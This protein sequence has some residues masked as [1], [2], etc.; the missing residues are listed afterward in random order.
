MR[1]F[2]VLRPVIAPWLVLLILV[3]VGVPAWAQALDLYSG[4]AMVV[5]Q[6]ESERQ[7]AVAPAFRSALIRASGDTSITDDARLAALLEQAPQWVQSYAFRQEIAAGPDGLASTRDFLQV[8]FDPEAVRQALATLDRS[9]WSERPRTL[10]W[11]VI[12]D[13]STRRI[14]S[15]AEVAALTALTRTALDR[16]I[17]LRLPQLDRE[18][19]VLVDADRLWSEPSP[20]ALAPAPRYGAAI[21]LVVRLARQGSG[22]SA[23]FSLLDGGRVEHW[24]GSYVDANAA[25]TAAANGLA[26]R[27]A[28]RFALS[29][30]ERVV[31]DYELRIAG[32]GSAQ[33][34]ARLMAYL[35]G[36]SVL[37]SF[38]L[39]EADGT[40]LTVAATLT[41][42]P[43]RLRQVLAIGG[44]LAF[45]DSALADPR[46]IALRLQR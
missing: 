7:R 8:R 13:G 31:A 16:G 17:E 32:V 18:D 24:S 36:L 33:D 43:A 38:A 41:V 4:T 35:N 12:E 19:L 40:T 45:D 15:A 11:L 2:A 1:L 30:A 21:A 26:D 10:V 9:V 28:Q 27:L 34:Y 23:R 42:A 20:S 22:W 39:R 37:Q 3:A 46:S 25:L 29:A 14:A 5:S 6:D 44:V